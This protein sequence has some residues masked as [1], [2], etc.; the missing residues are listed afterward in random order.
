MSVSCSIT[1]KAANAMS[2]MVKWQR[3]LDTPAYAFPSDCS[4]AIPCSWKAPT[5]P[6]KLFRNYPELNSPGTPTGHFLILLNRFL[7]SPPNP[8]GS[9][10]MSSM[11]PTNVSLV[12]LCVLGFSNQHD[13]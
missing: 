10:T 11:G 9:T 8:P 13:S 2:K 12:Q 6:A 4:A 1:E 3:L 5:L 7:F